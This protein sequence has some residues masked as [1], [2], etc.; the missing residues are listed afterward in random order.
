MYVCMYMYV[1][2]VCIMNVCMYRMYVCM[3]VCMYVPYVCYV[4]IS[5]YLFACICMNACKYGMY[6]T[7]N[8]VE[9]LLLCC[10]LGLNRIIFLG[11]K[12]RHT[13]HHAIV[14]V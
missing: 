13:A 11:P 12:G 4:C 3:Y 5:L 7:S 9:Y 10:G 6:G 1:C 8:H 2:T 14:A